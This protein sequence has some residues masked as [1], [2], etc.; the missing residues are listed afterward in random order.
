MLS[1]LFLGLSLA[2]AA[3]HAI[4]QSSGDRTTE[5]GEAAITSATAE[6]TPYDY[7]PLDA[8]TN[9]FPPNWVQPAVIP[10]SDATAA[11]L[12]AQI[13]PSIPTNIAPRGTVQGDFSG[14]NYNSSD[15]DCW[16]TYEQCTTP[17]LAGL[18]PDITGVPEVRQIV[19]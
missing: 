15:P 5:A 10:S 3:V 2:A 18:V 7:P 11:A 16:W 9:S 8:L 17:K 19:L 13:K 6:C 1:S 4:P 12:W 14:V